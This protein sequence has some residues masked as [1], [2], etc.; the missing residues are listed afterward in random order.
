MA[1]GTT[2]VDEQVLEHLERLLQ[3]DIFPLETF[4]DEI[5]DTSLEGTKINAYF[6][7]IKLDGNGRPMVKK[8]TDEMFHHLIHYVMPRKKIKTEGEDAKTQRVTFSR[9]IEEGKRL[10]VKNPNSGEGGEFLLYLIAEKYL[11]L[12][13]VLC[14]MPLKTSSNVHVHG[15][16]GIHVKYEKDTRILALYWC[17]SKLYASVGSA[18]DEC[19]A[20]VAPFLLEVGGSADR[21][22]RDLQLFRDNIGDNIDDTDMENAILEYLNP[23]HKNF[24]KCEYRGICLVGFDNDSYPTESNC[25]NT[26]QIKNEFR[27]QV[28]DWKDKLCKS[29]FKHEINT[30]IIEVF[31]LPFPSV[32]NFRDLF[33][34][35]LGI[36]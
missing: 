11:K 17:E 4:I 25:K 22:D 30:F 3:A 1:H 20:S 2:V 6:R 31:C 34:E 9:I 16:D 10:F 23:N 5:T 29:I 26:D 24:S 33:L 27:V 36:K 14:K 32:Q 18:I 12:P 21:Q 19:F 35:T 28:S 8:L 13:Q 7:F 15:T